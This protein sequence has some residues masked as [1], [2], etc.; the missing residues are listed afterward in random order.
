MTGEPYTEGGQTQ[1]CSYETTGWRAQEGNQGSTLLTLLV[2]LFV[3]V[4]AVIFYTTVS[5][6]HCVNLVKH[7]SASSGAPR[8]WLLSS[9][10]LPH[11]EDYL[12]P[13]C[14]TGWRCSSHE[15]VCSGP[16]P[17]LVQLSLWH[18]KLYRHL[19]ECL[20]NLTL[21]SP[22]REV[23]P[24]NSPLDLN[25][26]MHICISAQKG[27]VNVLLCKELQ[28]DGCCQQNSLVKL[29]KQCCI[30]NG[31]ISLNH[32]KLFCVSVC[33]S[34]QQCWVCGNVCL[35]RLCPR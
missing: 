6:K 12:I 34:E 4:S 32:M 35:V 8:V 9:Q 27:T 11:S 10:V 17:A 33:F 31:F 21:F 7:I 22:Y 13:P 28:A 15:Q 25:D 5:Y 3:F 18:M 29:Y 1:Y 30:D 23:K 16:D 2:L 20:M 14:T 19:Q 24:E 26:W